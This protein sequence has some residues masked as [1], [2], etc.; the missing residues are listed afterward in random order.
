MLPINIT[1]NFYITHQFHLADN[2][3]IYYD[4][5]L[6][7]DFLIK[8]KAILNYDCKTLTFPFMY[9]IKKESIEMNNVNPT[10][11]SKEALEEI[12]SPLKLN[13]KTNTNIPARTEKIIQIETSN[14]HECIV[15]GGEIQ[16]KVYLGNSLSK[17]IANKMFI[18]V[19]NANDSDITL[20]PESISKYVHDVKDYI[21]TPLDSVENKLTHKY[22]S[23]RLKILEENL[24]LDHM[25]IEERSSILQICREYND[26]F[27][28]PGDVLTT[29]TATTHKIPLLPNTPIINRKQYSRPRWQWDIINEHIEKL[30]N[31][32]LIVPSTSPY[33]SPVLVVPRK[34][35]KRWRV[36]VDF[37]ELNE[38]TLGDAYPLPNIE[39][40][41]QQ[42]GSTNYLS[43]LDM[44]EGFNQIPMDPEDAHKTAFT[45]PFGHH[46]WR[47]MPFGLKGAPARFQRLMDR[48]LIGLQGVKCFIYLDDLVIYAQ[49][50][51]EHN[52]KLRDIFDR[53]RYYNLKIQTTKCNFLKN[54]IV[55]LGHTISKQGISPNEEKIKDVINYPIPQTTKEVKQFVAL[56]SYYRKFVQNFSKIANPLLDLLKKDVTFH[57]NAFHDEAFQLL[58]EKLTT[59]P[60][61]IHPDY[62]K[63]FILTTDASQFAI[64]GVLSQG[65]IGSD[66]PIAYA[67]RRLNQAEQRYENTEREL[68]AI[69]YMCKYFR[70]FLYGRR[71]TIY[72]DNNALTWL[73]NIK[74]LNSRLT[75]FRLKL[76]EYDFIIKHKPGKQ[77]L[78]ADTLS[79]MPGRDETSVLTDCRHL[80][81]VTTRRQAKLLEEQSE[82]N[83]ETVSE[84]DNTPSKVELNSLNNPPMTLEKS[85]LYETLEENS[86]KANS[87]LNYD[88]F[89]HFVP[90]IHHIITENN[91]ALQI[92]VKDELVISIIKDVET[93]HADF[94]NKYKLKTTFFENFD[95]GEIRMIDKNFGI[96]L[97]D[98]IP[99][100]QTFNHLKLIYLLYKQK[101]TYT[102]LN[103]GITDKNPQHRFNLKM[104]LLYLFQNEI[105]PITIFTHDVIELK[106]KFDIVDIIRDFH[107]SPLGGH[108]GINRTVKRIQNYYHW[109]G[110]A[111][112]IEEFIQSCITCQK[113]KISR[114][115]KMPMKIT[116]T[117]SKP[118]E[119]IFLDTVGPLP[120]TLARN[121]YILTFQDDLTK[122]SGAIAIPDQEAETI[123][124]K[125]V[126]EII[127]RYGAPQVILSDQGRE[128]LAK[129]F[130]HVCKLLRARKI[131]TSAYH[132]QSNPVERIH[133]GLKEYLRN[134]A[135]NDPYD[136]CT[137][138]PYAMFVYNTTPHTSTNFTPF[139]LLFGHIA[140]LPQTLKN[141]PETCYNYDTYA[142]ILKAKFRRSHELARQSIN[143]HKT[144]SK[145]YYDKNTKQINLNT[146]DQVLLRNNARKNK[147]EQIWTGPYFVTGVIS[148]ENTIIK[149]KNKN[150]T[151]HNNR[152]KLFKEH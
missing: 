57:W 144:K 135:D 65:E 60:I 20:S 47:V 40:I 39:D 49:T 45:T 86:S 52:Q 48:V 143:S 102:N 55:Y 79:R 34:G 4:A 42:L 62:E 149:V 9:L 1:N 96:L 109:T 116:S 38:H 125:F 33:N 53:F 58:K 98:L 141:A 27:H 6:G 78:N 128:F 30:K 43:V 29:V 150:K 145:Q 100:E 97:S 77:N 124:E 70:H 117:A 16:E 67:S 106:N 68:L 50:L 69:V 110:M 123:A 146:G 15:L 37:R 139:E 61:L 71:F 76:E 8:N 89:F 95:F 148:P 74:D 24:K 63:E 101:T 112:D 73:F 130:T 136:W 111:R 107:V 85:P 72:T 56:C 11:P 51:E 152:L 21:V 133:R 105:I 26:L 18:T 25:N 44:A 91:K 113:N 122:F 35:P 2:F 13:T 19:V 131:K 115:N 36:V 28:L 82:E 120:I 92:P 137:W 14:S 3:E 88:K 32:E 140:D 104:V 142:N 83:Q 94:I 64:G 132:P 12:P 81:L 31:S 23:N 66:R 54:E 103:I 22:K 46:E 80:L 119:K 134:Y 108:Q 5:V 151:V 75:K 127:C 59:A 147:L 90:N 121:K 126:T 99:T 87:E 114:I 93:V 17:P 118:F 138:L 84:H 41:L 129:C 7:N 10:L